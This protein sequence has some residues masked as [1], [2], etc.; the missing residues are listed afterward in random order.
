MPSTYVDILSPSRTVDDKFCK[1]L[2]PGGLVLGM[3]TFRTATVASHRSPQPNLVVGWASGLM[4]VWP[5]ENTAID[6]PT[7][8][9]R[10]I[11]DSLGTPEAV[12]RV[13]AAVDGEDE[14]TYRRRHL[15]DAG[16]VLALTHHTEVELLCA[17]V[18]V[19]GALSPSNLLAV[20]HEDGLRERQLIA[21]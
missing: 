2:G 5:A 14:A 9:G 17:A 11:A 7:P 1:V 18:D 6:A 12:L 3:S 15:S 8:V 10:R 21:S 4:Q 13:L 16:A 20:L 19:R